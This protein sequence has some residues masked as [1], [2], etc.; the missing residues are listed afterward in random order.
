MLLQGRTV[1]DLAEASCDVAGDG[2]TSNR[3][4]GCRRRYKWDNLGRFPPVVEV[5]AVAEASA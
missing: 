3:N 5:V 4:R 2:D 1:G